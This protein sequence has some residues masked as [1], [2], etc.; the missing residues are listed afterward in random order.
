MTKFK[1]LGTVARALAKIDKSS[2]A[3]Q[4][5]DQDGERWKKLKVPVKALVLLKLSGN[6]NDP[7]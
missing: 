7:R 5:N 1:N 3:K 2:P 4:T 6:K